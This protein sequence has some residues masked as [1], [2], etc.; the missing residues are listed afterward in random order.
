MALADAAVAFKSALLTEFG[1][2]YGHP[3]ASRLERVHGL[4]SPADGTMHD[5]GNGDVLI[6]AITSCTNTSNPSVLIA[7]GLLRARTPSPRA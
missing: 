1:K 3:R 5:V 2:E 7:A 4:G 6:A